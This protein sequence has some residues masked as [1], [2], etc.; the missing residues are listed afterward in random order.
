MERNVCSFIPLPPPLLLAPP[1]L[2]LPLRRPL[3]LTP[4]TPP[5]PD[6]RQPLLVELLLVLEA[7]YT[8]FQAL[9]FS[10]SASRLG[11]FISI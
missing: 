1:L 2:L 6:S 11:L 4:Q 3:P 5:L 7:L 8:A 9:C 10:A